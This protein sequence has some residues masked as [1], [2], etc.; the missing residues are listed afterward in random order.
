LLLNYFDPKEGWQV[1]KPQ[2]IGSLKIDEL[3]NPELPP[4]VKTIGI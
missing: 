3:K 4:T 2:G 1:F